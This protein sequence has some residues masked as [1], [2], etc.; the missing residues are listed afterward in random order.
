MKVLHVISDS[1]IGGAGVLLTSLLRH[2]DRDR[3]QSVVALP[4]DSVL[5][6]QIAPLGI[7][8]R[9]LEHP[10][11][12]P[13]RRSVSEIGR[14]IRADGVDVV[15]ANAAINARIAGHFQKNLVVYTRHCCY[16]PSGI[17]RLR[18]VQWIGG[19]WNNA[20]CDHAIATAYAARDD[21][22]RLGVDESKI[23]VIVN[24]AEPM[25][26][27]TAEELAAARREW[28]IAPNAY[29]V[30]ICARLE[31]CK[32]HETFLRAAQSVLRNCDREV[33]FLIVGEGSRRAALE[34]T[35]Q[36]MG[37]GEAVRF[38]GFLCDVA[39]A[40]RLMDLNVNCSSGTETSCLAISEGMSA[41]V[42]AI[43]SDYGGNRDMV[44]NDGLAG[45]VYPVGD[46]EAL[47]NAI[48]AVMNDRELEERMC[49]AARRRYLD[50]FSPHRMTEEVTKV[51]ESLC[52][53]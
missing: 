28:G 35:V 43:V 29:V 52:P 23:T 26:E 5:I 8:I 18:S 17:W 11:D 19:R 13:S 15:H 27:V 1:N 31:A 4:C 7:P 22:C 39:R 44:G 12:R 2:F 30:G 50:A 38:T 47:A 37:I 48:R 16:P 33:C 45:R 46:S 3:V 14:I 49:I 51:Y 41:G 34:R 21:I 9:L 10:A 20:L 53:P 25:R 42:P 32:G 40:Y 24:G 36:A 6:G